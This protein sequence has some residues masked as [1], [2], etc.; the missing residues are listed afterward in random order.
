MFGLIGVLT[1]REEACS[2]M[3][4]DLRRPSG[5]QERSCW[6]AGWR[7]RGDAFPLPLYC[8]ELLVPPSC[9]LTKTTTTTKKPKRPNKLRKASRV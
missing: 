6:V 7:L 8:R 3:Q 1:E 2:A 9:I 5:A 4:P